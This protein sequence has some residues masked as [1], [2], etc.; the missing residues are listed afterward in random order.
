MLQ[1]EILQLMELFLLSGWEKEKLTIDFVPLLETIED[2]SNATQI[3][4][5]LYAHPFYKK[6]LKRRFNK[7][8]IM[9]GFSDSTKDGGYLMANWSILK[10]KVALTSTARNNDVEL[11]FFDGRGGP[12]ARGGGK[13]HLF[14]ASMGK[15]VANDHIQLTIQGQT[16]SSQYGSFDSAHYNME[17][18]INAGI[19]SSFDQNNINTLNN[20]QTDLIANLAGE[21]YQVFAALTAHPLFLKYLE[22]HSPLK[23]LS[24]INISS[25]PVKRN[26]DAELRLEDLRAISFVTAWSQL[27][28][29]IPGY[30]GVGSALK[31]AKDAGSFNDIKQLYIESGQFKTMIDNCMMS[32]SKSD[33]RV[34][35]YLENDDIFGQFWRMI[36][37][38]FELTRDLLLEVSDTQTLMEKYPVE[39][40]SIALREKIVLP[41]VIIQHYALQQLNNMKAEKIVNA[42]S[43][44]YDKLII[45][46]VYGIVNAGRNLV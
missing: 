36:K 16:I 32:M 38:E 34:T 7:Q 39:R 44:I 31:K 43:E 2:L 23:L 6:H 13:T 29:N 3:M 14:Y 4:E 21:S 28:Q 8:T 26:V 15:D 24:Q 18:L 45:R 41:L 30:Y 11:V 22:K 46:T 10:A 37:E 35:A 25:R 5:T 20:A 19:V 12:P 17:Q 27:K 9:L 42:Q 1:L 33:F 40:K